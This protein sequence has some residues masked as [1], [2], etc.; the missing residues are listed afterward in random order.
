MVMW[1]ENC[2]GVAADTCITHTVA[3]LSTVLDRLN[4]KYMTESK[5]VEAILIVSSD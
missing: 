2:Q 5:S 4:Q 1:C 3:H